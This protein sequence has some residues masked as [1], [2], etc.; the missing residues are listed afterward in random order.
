VVQ[1]VTLKLVAAFVEESV[2]LLP[3]LEKEENENDG[4]DGLLPQWRL[5]PCASKYFFFFLK[6]F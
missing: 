5:W 3:I 4:V 6:M 2:L 1:V